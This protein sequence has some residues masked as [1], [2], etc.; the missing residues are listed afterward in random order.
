MARYLFS[1]QQDPHTNNH[2]SSKSSAWWSLQNHARF[3]GAH[4][5]C[6][7]RHEAEQV[8]VGWNSQ[9]GLLK[10]VAL[11]LESQQGGAKSMVTEEEA[12]MRPPVCV[13]G[14]MVRSPSN[15]PRAA[16]SD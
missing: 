10:E 15:G 4:E 3:W 9:E 11:S 12:G 5:K 2:N 7:Q 6:P 14:A 13:S 1:P 16:G 8:P